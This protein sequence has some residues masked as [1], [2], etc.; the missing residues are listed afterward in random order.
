M[1]R[2]IGL[3]TIWT[4]TV[5]SLS[6]FRC[7]DPP[8]FVMPAVVREA[9]PVPLPYVLP[10]EYAPWVIRYCDE[11]GVPVWMASRMFGQESAGNPM[12]LHWDPCAVSWKGAQGLAQLMPQ[13]LA[14]FAERYNGGRKI[15]PFDPETAI[16]VGQRLLADL[17]G[18]T[19][20]WYIAHEAYNGGLAYFLDPRRYG[21]WPAESVAHARA[22]VGE[23]R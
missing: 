6:S 14:L 8:A 20:S 10:A 5:I 3:L 16:R 21:P 2:A 9:R 23:A 22:I 1:T 18:T 7:A 13:Y 11:T 12:A 17:H 4:V 15:D 19:G